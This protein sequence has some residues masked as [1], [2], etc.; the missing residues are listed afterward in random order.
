MEVEPSGYSVNDLNFSRV[1]PLLSFPTSRSYVSLRSVQ[2]DTDSRPEATSRNL[3][4]PAD[5]LPE[6]ER[7]L[8]WAITNLYRPGDVVHLLHVVPEP[9]TTHS[10]TGVYVPPDE[11]AV[12][13]SEIQEAKAMFKNRFLLTLLQHEVPF[14]LHIVVASVDKN[15]VARAISDEAHA[16]NAAAIVIG[17]QLKSKLQEMWGGSVAASAVAKVR[18][19][20]IL[21]R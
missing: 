2:T 6:S 20:V 15:T 18:R 16:I 10:W 11:A 4:V 21:V 7:A 17:S 1:P 14:R 13:E 19:P 8:L 5:D 9:S 12:E 3:L